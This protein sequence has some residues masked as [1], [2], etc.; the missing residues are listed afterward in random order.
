MFDG[1]R[2][3]NTFMFLFRRLIKQVLVAFAVGFVIKRLLASSNPRAQ[4]AGEVAD[5]YLG[6]LFGFSSERSKR[7]RPGTAPVTRT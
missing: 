4:R 3:Y 5:R 1:R 7:R 6:R 2:G